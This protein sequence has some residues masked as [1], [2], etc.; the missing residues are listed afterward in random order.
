MRNIF[1]LQGIIMETLETVVNWSN[2]D[3]F[4]NGI[5]DAINKAIEKHGDGKGLVT[6]R[7]THCHIDGVA[8]YYTIL[9]QGKKG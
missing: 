5:K 6:V 2:F 1:L 8:P 9:M 4:N 3:K 7:I